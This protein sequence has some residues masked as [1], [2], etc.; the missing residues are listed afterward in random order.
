MLKRKDH[1]QEEKYTVD[2]AAEKT[3]IKT[4]ENTLGYKKDS[5]FVVKLNKL[6]DKAPEPIFTADGAYAKDQ[7]KPNNRLAMAQ[8]ERTQLEKLVAAKDKPEVLKM[9]EA[10]TLKGPK[11]ASK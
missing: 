1:T 5:S 4:L 2:L 6:L 8:W 11:L 9:F 7:P 3:A 10:E